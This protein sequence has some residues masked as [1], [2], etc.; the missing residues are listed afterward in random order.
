M[1]VEDHAKEVD[2]LLKTKSATMKKISAIPLAIRDWVS[3]Y[4]LMME[5]AV[6]LAAFEVAVRPVA[7]GGL[8]LSDARGANI[9]KNLTVNFNRKGQVDAN[10]DRCL[11]SL[12]PPHKGRTEWRERCWSLLP[13]ERENLE[14]RA[15]QRTE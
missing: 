4:N 15:C 10:S 12:M 1:S 3:D 7:D 5:N 2:N 14:G 6:R 8:G 9:A 13:V 11:R